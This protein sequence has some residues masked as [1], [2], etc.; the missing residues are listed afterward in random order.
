MG[1]STGPR[2]SESAKVVAGLENMKNHTA[3]RF[4]NS[5]W[6]AVGLCMTLIPQP[7][8]DAGKPEFNVLFI[9]IDD[10]NTRLHCYGH[11]QIHSPNI[12]RLAKRGTSAQPKATNHA[13]WR[14]G[15]K[16][17]A[18]TKRMRRRARAL[19]SEDSR[20]ITDPSEWAKRSHRLM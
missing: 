8:C 15:K 20:V 17:P 14:M 11:D 3:V 18:A 16:A 6:L 2:M 5:P 9:A 19:K 1:L 10:Q 4:R 13:I 12:D 7:T